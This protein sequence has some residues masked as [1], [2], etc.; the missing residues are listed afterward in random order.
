MFLAGI[1]AKRMKL[2]YGMSPPLYLVFGTDII[3]KVISV[4]CR[5]QDVN[6]IGP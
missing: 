6:R 5:K 1:Q 4:E 3:E 2:I